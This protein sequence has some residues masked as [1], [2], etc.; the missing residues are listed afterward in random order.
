MERTVSRKVLLRVLGNAGNVSKARGESFIYTGNITFI[1]ISV[2]NKSVWNVISVRK[3]I[4]IGPPKILN[5]FQYVKSMIHG[6]MISR[7]TISRVFPFIFT[8][9][10]FTKVFVMIDEPL[11]ALMLY[12]SAEWWARVSRA[13]WKKLYDVINRIKI[14][15]INNRSKWKKRQH[16]INFP[17]ENGRKYNANLI[18]INIA[19]RSIARDTRDT[20][21]KINCL[22]TP[23]AAY[24][25]ISA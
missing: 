22:L 13:H 17:A 3:N 24:K 4:C 14:R 5:M 9:Y 10:Q 12:N 16:E 21:T 19:F 8:R 7:K 18:I 20:R 23:E 15:S 11:R 1:E 25:T 6:W 2:A